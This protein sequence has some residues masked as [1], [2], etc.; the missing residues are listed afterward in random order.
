MCTVVMR[1][2]T[3]GTGLENN[4]SDECLKI[5]TGETG[6]ISIQSVDRDAQSVR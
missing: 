3:V 2:R 4:L 6:L 5:F 1:I